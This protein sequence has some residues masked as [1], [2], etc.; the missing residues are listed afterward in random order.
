MIFLL[1]EKQ[2]KILPFLFTCVYYLFTFTG[3]KKKTGKK[4]FALDNDV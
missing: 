1:S 3:I 4:F 2:K